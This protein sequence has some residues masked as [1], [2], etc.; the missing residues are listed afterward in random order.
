V[1]SIRRDYRL[2]VD[3]HSG[4]IDAQEIEVVQLVPEGELYYRDYGEALRPIAAAAAHSGDRYVVSRLHAR[5]ADAMQEAAAEVERR[6]EHLL[7]LAAR[8]REMKE[9][10]HG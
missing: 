2:T 10:Q 6:G 8:C 4:S 3:L 9:V 7:G 1:D 5:L